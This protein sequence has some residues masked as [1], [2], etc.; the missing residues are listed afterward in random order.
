MIP[1]YTNPEMGAIWTDQHR[2]GLWLRVELALCAVLAERRIIPARAYD[3]IRKRAAVSAERITAIE[4]TVKHDVIAFVSAVSERIGEAGKYLHYGV[5]SSDI[6]DTA[7]ALQLQEATDL[8]AARQERLRRTLAHTAQRYRRAPMVGRS[9]GVHGEPITF[10]W[11]VAIW[12]EEIRRHEARLARA[13]ATISVGKLSGS[14]GTYAH[15]SPAIESAVCARLGLTPAPITNQV[16]QRDRHADYMQTLALIA[17]SIEKMAT[18]IRHL[19]RTEVRE[20]EELFAEGQRGSSSMPHKR[21]PIGSENLC[22]L[23]RVVRANSQ[24][25]LE[26]VALWHERD[27]SHSSVERIILPDSTILL[28]FMLARMESILSTLRVFP[29]RMRANLESTGGLI[30][31]QQLMLRLVQEGMTREEAYAL[32]QALATKAWEGGTPFRTLVEREA[33]IT[34][35][36]SP[37]EINRCFSVD[38][39]LTHVDA[40]F[41]RLFPAETGKRRASASRRRGGSAAPKP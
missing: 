34:R 21:N 22:G 10:G 16:I 2:Y 8:L 30:F 28:D 20:V 41:A 27:I 24:A 39:F 3:T 35:R 40:V 15:L 38:Q 17:A 1:R 36:L 6:L 9:H 23:A 29:D 19:Q 12:H 37:A 26:N 11:K 33:R 14:M 32:V 7:L 18:E 5:T 31:S 13:R 25:A 4:Q